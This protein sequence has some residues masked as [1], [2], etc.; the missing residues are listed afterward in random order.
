MRGYSSLE[1]EFTDKGNDGKP[2]ETKKT[3]NDNLLTMKKLW[4]KGEGITV[5]TNGA[6][7]VLLTWWDNEKFSL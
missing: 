2:M 1:T 5:S 6:S 7:G 4:V 3:A